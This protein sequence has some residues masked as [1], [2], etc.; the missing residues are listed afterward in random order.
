MVGGA[1]PAARR[2][3][4]PARCMFARVVDLPNRSPSIFC[5]DSGP[6]SLGRARSLVTR[7]SPHTTAVASL[8]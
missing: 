1:P 7:V 4:G 8:L 2:Q 6:T 3:R 5:C